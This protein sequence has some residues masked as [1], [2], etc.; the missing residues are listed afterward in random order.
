MTVCWPRINR[1]LKTV[2]R[3]SYN[4]QLHY[5]HGEM[6][7]KMTL[8]WK[9]VDPALP[10]VRDVTDWCHP[11]LKFCISLLSYTTSGHGLRA[12]SQTGT[13]GDALWTHAQWC[14]RPGRL[15]PGSQARSTS[16]AAGFGGGPRVLWSVGQ[17]RTWHRRHDDVTAADVD[18]AD[19][20]DVM[21]RRIPLHRRQLRLVHI[22]NQLY[23]LVLFS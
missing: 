23:R 4:W 6:T 13:K 19:H 15:A 22:L 8:R 14:A 7:S 21:P 18:D 16:W 10:L 5:T 17:L 2:V 12:A 20:S 3:P 9:L 11:T 1:K